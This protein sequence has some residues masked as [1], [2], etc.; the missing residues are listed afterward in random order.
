MEPS[1]RFNIEWIVIRANSLQY[2]Q[3]SAIVVVSL[4]ADCCKSCFSCESLRRITRKAD[5]CICK[6]KVADQLHGFHNI[7][8][9]I[10]L[11]QQNAEDRFSRDATYICMRRLVFTSAKNVFFHDNAQYVRYMYVTLW[12]KRGY[13]HSRNLLVFL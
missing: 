7:D 8:S 10:P 11:L 6:N 2:C 13:D 4:R 3:P 1:L 9:T 12:Y 5:F